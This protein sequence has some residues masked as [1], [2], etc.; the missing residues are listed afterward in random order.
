[1]PMKSKLYEY[2][3]ENTKKSF[4]FLDTL[5]LSSYLK[6]GAE[7]WEIM[8]SI[9][10]DYYENHANELPGFLNGDIFSFLSLEDFQ[11]YL[12]ETYRVRFKHPVILEGVEGR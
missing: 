8:T 3:D 12:E 1:M 2:A 11:Q 5:D 10:D 9:E 4:E 6:E 7:I